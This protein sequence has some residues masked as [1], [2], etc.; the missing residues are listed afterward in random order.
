MAGI[1]Q[2]V[3]HQRFCKGSACGRLFF[4]C[5]HCDR[6]QRYCSPGCRRQ[7]RLEQRRAARRRHQQSIEGRLDHRDRQRAYRLR[8]AS[9]TRADLKES[10][11]DHGS[12]AGASSAIMS[13][14]CKWPPEPARFRWWGRLWPAMCE[15]GMIVCSFCGRVGRFLNPFH[16]PG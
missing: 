11:T 3:F 16:E 4:V 14:P 10:V 12:Q 15:P 9:T 6:G 7:S 2:T 1:S 13:A 8:K 5:H